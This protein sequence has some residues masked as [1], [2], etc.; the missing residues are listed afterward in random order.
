MKP[1]HNSELSRRRCSEWTSLR[2][3]QPMALLMPRPKSECSR[4][5][6]WQALNVF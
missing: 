4:A 6:C 1:V 5:C 3:M 2:T